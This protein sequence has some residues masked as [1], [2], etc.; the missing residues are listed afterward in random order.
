[1]DIGQFIQEILINFHIL[2][3]SVFIMWKIA[4]ISIQPK[5]FLQM[6]Y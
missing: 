1:M 6:E 4:D 2:F 5:F 3:K